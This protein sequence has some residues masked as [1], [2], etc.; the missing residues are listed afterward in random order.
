MP[1]QKPGKSN[2]QLR[3]GEVTESMVTEQ[4]TKQLNSVPKGIGG[5]KMPAIPTGKKK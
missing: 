2:W 5:Q 1:R 4:G 3:K